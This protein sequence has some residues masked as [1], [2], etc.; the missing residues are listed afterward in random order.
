MG[1]GRVR[2]EDGV[3]WGINFL[4]GSLI[5][6]HGS[7]IGL[8]LRRAPNWE[9]GLGASF[10]LHVGLWRLLGLSHGRVVRFQE[11]P[12]RTRK[13]LH[14]LSWPDSAGP[15]VHVYHL[16]PPECIVLEFATEEH[17]ETGCGVDAVCA[18]VMIYFT[19]PLFGDVKMAGCLLLFHDTTM[20]ILV[21]QVPLVHHFVRIHSLSCN[22]WVRRNNIFK[23]FKK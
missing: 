10:A 2:W 12:Q 1:Q 13:R 3:G 19:D 14:G 18:T 15:V 8:A 6:L 21:L 20:R 9:C 17:V 11:C 4:H 7:L 22:S 23:A 5:G 16:H